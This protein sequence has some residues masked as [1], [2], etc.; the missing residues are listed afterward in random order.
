MVTWLAGK[1][2]FV[3]KK[4]VRDRLRGSVSQRF[5]A[6]AQTPQTRKHWAHADGMAAD[7]AADPATRTILRNRARYE[8][9]NNPYMAGQ[10]RTLA[11]D[12][13]GIG[14]ALQLLTPNE[15]VNT[16][17]EAR[18]DEWAEAARLASKLRMVREVRAADGEIFIRLV[19]NP[20]LRTP[21]K[22]DIA[23]IEADQCF[24][25]SFSVWDDQPDGIELD[26]YGNP[27]FYWFAKN[28]PGDIGL[29]SFSP[30][31]FTRVPARDVM[32][33]FKQ[34]RPGQHRGLPEIVSSLNL[35][36]ERRNYR[37]STLTAARAVA[38]LGAV[39]LST[40]TEA[41]INELPAEFDSIEIEQGMMTQAPY[42]TKA[43]QMRPEQP[44]TTYRD[45]NEQLINEQAR[46]LNMPFNIAA[47]DSS[48]YNFASGRLDHQVYDRTVRIDQQEIEDIILRPI[49]QAWSL[50]AT[51]IP[52]YLPG[53]AGQVYL[54]DRKDPDWL[55]PCLW[56]WGDRDHVDPAKEASAT[57]TRLR[58]RTSTLAVEY[59]R[60]RRDWRDEIHQSGREREALDAAGLWQADAQ[61]APRI[62]E[63][64]KA[65]PQIG[66]LA[67]IEM[68]L[69]FGVPESRAAVI[70]EHASKQPPPVVVPPNPTADLN[71]SAS[72]NGRGRI[73]EVSR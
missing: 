66:K 68:L 70:V 12:V 17:V 24:S 35:H 49:I 29:G 30:D 67:A 73:L 52:N 51:S 7:V 34:E 40:E 45:F 62:L 1:L 28:H 44:S 57:E 46:P 48:K 22:L 18:F 38:S 16:N 9:F 69:V 65:I 72:R 3:S 64:V 59:A 2:G 41:D 58:T 4:R 6:A 37:Q 31:D 11:N 25:P 5:D 53:R 8:R 56:I 13:I 54:P 21:V 43:S 27:A 26:R 39:I 10:L 33:F 47:A 71:G 63:V 50:E 61:L 55:V 23:L 15:S 36:A 14:P 20:M 32:H 19:H 42:G 60:T